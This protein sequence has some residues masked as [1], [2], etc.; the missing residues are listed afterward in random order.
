MEARAI[1]PAVCAK[2]VDRI[3]SDRTVSERHGATRRVTATLGETLGDGLSHRFT[4]TP[5]AFRQA[6]TEGVR[7]MPSD[8]DLAVRCIQT[9]DSLLSYIL[10]LSFPGSTY[11]VAPRYLATS[12]GYRS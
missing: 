1:Y 10:S 11:P 3:V 5:N 2:S 7:G 6:A 12:H 4:H 8:A 9:S